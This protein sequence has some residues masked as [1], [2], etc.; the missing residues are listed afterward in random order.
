MINDLPILSTL[1][2]EKKDVKF[3]GNI[4]S[5]QLTGDKAQITIEIDRETFYKLNKMQESHKAYLVVYD[6]EQ[7]YEV[8][9]KLIV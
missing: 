2:A 7:Y 4:L 5:K 6:R 1:I 9:K 8:V 3:F